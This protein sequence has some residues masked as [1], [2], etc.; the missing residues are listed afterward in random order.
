M[1]HLIV[2]PPQASDCEVQHHLARR[3]KGC[4]RRY[5]EEPLTL[6]IPSKLATTMIMSQRNNYRA[7]DALG[8]TTGA[9]RYE[10]IYSHSNPRSQ[11]GTLCPQA[12]TTR[13]NLPVALLRPCA[14]QATPPEEAPKAQLAAAREPWGRE[15]WARLRCDGGR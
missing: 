8:A 14:I 7:K 12:E 3:C 9:Q 13:S 11:P 1:T 4:T 10:S 6:I 2:A 5:H 15:V